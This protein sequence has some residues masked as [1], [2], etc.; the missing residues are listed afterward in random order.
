MEISFGIIGGL[1]I[2]VVLLAIGLP[3]PWVFLASSIVALILLDSSLGFVGATAFH[4]LYNYLLMAIAFFIFAGT[5]M[6]QSGIAD[7]L[8]RLANSL[9]GRIRGGMAAVGVVSTLFLSSLTGSSLPCISVMIPIMV[10]RLEKFGYDRR[11]STAILCASSFLGYLIPPSV[12]VL[13]YALVSVTSVAA[14]FLSTVFPGILLAGGYLIVNYFY[15]PKWMKPTDEV[16]ELPTTFKGRVKEVGIST[17]LALPALGS[18]LIILGGIYGG[19][20]TPSEAGA[21][22]VVYT[23]LIGLFVYRKLKLKNT[24]EMTKETLTTLGMFAALLAFATVFVRVLI[25]EGVAQ[26]G[27]EFVMGVFTE[28]YLILL[29]LNIFVLI[30]GMFIDGFPIMLVVV[31]LILPLVTGIGLNLVQLGAMVVINVGIGV[32]TPPYAIALFVGS[33]LADVPYSQIVRPLLPFLFFV[34]IPVLFLTTYFPW[35]S[36][37]LPTLVMGPKIV[38][39]W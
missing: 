14:V 11:Y 20:F 33:R 6:S 15:S 19:V 5:L 30:L 9:V 36:L 17:W 27:A 2:F 29:M 38:G 3:I 13:I 24:W 28:P 39:P 31:P 26:S 22:A 21:V 16:A 8:I 32:I 34:A 4:S 37:W 1:V 12:P 25:R 23:L 35:L 7:S 10:P 18:P